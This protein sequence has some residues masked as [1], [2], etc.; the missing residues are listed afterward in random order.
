MKTFFL[1]A[2]WVFLTACVGL[3]EA[4]GLN[5]RKWQDGDIIFSSSAQGQGE[6]IIAATDSPFTHCGMVFSKGG[7]WLVLEAVQP[8][9]AVS[10]VDFI[11]RS[12][13][14]KVTVRRLKSPLSAASQSKARAWA[15]AQ[16]GKD[17]DPRFLWDD[18]NLYC[19]EYVWKAYRQGGVELCA[20]RHFR[21]YDL[22]KPAVR[23]IIKQRFGGMAKVPLNEQV[24][25]PSDLAA[26]PLL[27]DVPPES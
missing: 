27:V 13:A 21:D 11:S 7:K 18:G 16:I 26:S 9:G 25:A 3:A 5:S 15:E 10:L 22:E 24:V 8:V 12:K 1:T 14:G 17:Y 4:E 6:A 19:S 2:S 23:K 20:L